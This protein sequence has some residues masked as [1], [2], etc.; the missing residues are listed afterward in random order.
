MSRL[1]IAIELSDEQKESLARLK[2]DIPQARWVPAAQLHLTLAF[3]GD[4]D[5]Q[6]LPKLKAALSAISSPGFTLRFSSPSCFPDRRR[7]RVLWI[8]LEKEPLLVR[9][10]EQVHSAVSSCAIFLD[11]RPFSPHITLARLKQSAAGELFGFL[12]VVADIPP[13]TV[14]GFTLFQSRL[15]LG[16]AMHT[17]IERYSLTD[18]GA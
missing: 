9:L 4:V 3:L 6:L 13:L 10:A 16:G 2:C 17:P 8:G 15:S 12:G 5:E 7:P 18:R 14:H 1:F 11:E